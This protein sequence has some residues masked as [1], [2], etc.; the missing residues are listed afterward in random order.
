M[1]AGFTMDRSA[2][3]APLAISFINTTQGASVKA[4]YEWNFGNG[5]TSLLKDPG[6]VFLDARSYAI[7]LTVKDSNKTSSVTQNIIVY[8]KPAVDFTASLQK[9]CFPLPVTFTA[10]ATAGDGTISQ[11]LW[12]FGDG[13]T[14]Q[15]NSSA[16]THTY[17]AKQNPVI[18]LSVTNS[19]G[20]QATIVKENVVKVL[21]ELKASFTTDKKVLCTLNDAAN[22]INTSTGPGTLSY[23]W[24]FG[25]GQTSTTREPSH[26]YS[27]KG[28][29]AVRL[30]VSSSE[31]CKDTLLQNESL[32]VANYKTDWETT[33][34]LCEENLVK[35]INKSSPAPDQSQWDFGN[36]YP[37]NTTN[38]NVET[39]YPVSGT[40]NVK[41][42]NTFGNCTDVLNKQVIVHDIPQLS[43]F[44]SEISGVCGAP[45]NVN[46]KD[47]TTGAVKWEW[48]ADYHN[49]QSTLKEPSTEFTYD[50]DW[51]VY[52]KVFNDKGCSNITSKYL[53]IRRPFV[54]INSPD[55]SGNGS[56]NS[57][58]PKTA[59]FFTTSSVDIAAYQWNFGD[60]G[61]STDAKPVHT[62]SKEGDY[63]VNLSYTTVT[64]CTGT[65]EFDGY[66]AIRDKVKAD[67]TVS[68]TN[69][70]GNTPLYI[71]SN[72]TAPYYWHN[73]DMGDGVLQP[74]EGHQ[75]E[76]WYKY[77]K[78]GIYTVRLAISNGIC[79]DTLIKTNLIKVSPPFPKI[80]GF[81]NTC[82]GTRGTVTFTQTSKQANSWHWDFGDGTTLSLNTDQPEVKHTY[83]KTG[84]YKV[85]LNT[86]NGAC[87]VGDSILVNVLLKQH[88]VLTADKTVICRTEDYL[89]IT[90]SNLERNPAYY[91]HYGYGYGDW[92][93]RDGSF[94]PGHVSAGS[95]NDMPFSHTLWDFTPGP[96]RQ[97]L[98]LVVT[99]NYF[100]CRDTTNWIPLKINGPIPGFKQIISNPC[101]NGSMITLQDTSRSSDNVALKSWEWNF[102]DGTTQTTT[103]RTVTHSYGW[104]GTYPVYLKVTDVNGCYA[105][106][107]G[108]ANAEKNSLD[109]NFIASATT[110]SPGTTINFSNTSVT[111][112]IDHTTYKWLLGDGSQLTTYDAVKTYTQPGLYTVKLIARNTLNGCSDTASLVITVK[113]INAAFNIDQSHTSISQCPP[114]LVK[115]TNISSNI[116]KITWDFG[117]GTIVND[118]FNP[119]HIYT[120]PGKYKIVLLTESDNG[121]K[122][123]TEDSVIIK[124]PAATMTA[125]ILHSCTAQTI[126]LSAITENA[127]NYLWD[128]G[129]GTVI[130]S[131]DTFSAHRYQAAGIYEPKLI[132]ADANGCAAPVTLA[133]KIVIDSLFISLDN[134]PE[135]ICSPK[136]VWLDPTIVSVAASQGQQSLVYHWNFGTGNTRDTSNIQ[137]PSFVYQQPGTYNVT[138]TVKS[139]YGC[140]KETTH[141]IVAYQGLGGSINGPA[142]ICEETTAQF[143]G[144]T[145]IPGQPKWEWIFHD[146]TV[147]KQQN[148]PAKLYETPG[149]Y[150]VKLLVDNNGCV[151]TLTHLL[152]VKAKPAITL[153]AKELLLCQGSLLKITAGGGSVYAWSPAIGLNTTT[154]AE[155]TASPLNDMVYTVTVT[156]ADGCKNTDSVNITVAYPFTLQLDN[157]ATICSGKSIELKASGADSYQWIQNTI[158]LNNT[159]IANPVATPAI[160][161]TYTVRA[162]DANHCFTN[163]ASINVIVQ[164]LPTIDAGPGAELFAGATYQIKPTASNDVINWNWSPAKYLSCSNCPSPETKPLEPMTYAVVVTNAA[165]C[166]ATDTVVIKMLC[167]K[168]KIYVP[169]A[170]T[171]NNDGLNDKFILKGYGINKVKYLRIYN[172]WGELVFERNNFQM[173]D[174]GSA[175]DGTYK[176]LLVPNGAYI[177]MAE[178]SCNDQV[179]TEKGT[180]TV[181]Y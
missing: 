86:T 57:C 156:N 23:S 38:I 59:S 163:T 120:K 133:D 105:Y 112:D 121:T 95:L 124:A 99:S 25:D 169:S 21:E 63:R 48:R 114:V 137:R 47:T 127:A 73:W 40:Y 132:A 177:Y 30:A 55:I 2:G 82:E 111:S 141:S 9:G 37:Q 46:F 41:L 6:A 51:Y 36:A 172:R 173:N 52:L 22:F 157:E 31:G 144:V 109:A 108:Y 71:K 155:V 139:P 35:I 100:G 16:T 168:S 19:Y 72:V 14:E 70:C 128:F 167:D 96:G 58:G 116:S 166:T 79:F 117:D 54:K 83:T 98:R 104:P 8:K 53:V 13:F 151:D 67:F 94:A 180:V 158:G 62:Y 140:L 77:E 24:D 92:H 65:V 171:P 75:K 34:L 175:W 138:L 15:V 76:M 84:W 174:A 45:V 102:G 135:K 78:D 18:N 49:F 129:D 11:Y 131:L 81:S 20:C 149:S 130:Q 142:S 115:F 1:K 4:V 5:N 17:T 28:I 162:I 153:S 103:T 136:E 69:I 176:G 88:P 29:Y 80:A 123:T 147:I 119:S 145:L 61:S 26:T 181:V 68:A 42:T 90:V 165:G 56:I 150:P 164:S 178:M 32:N 60:G 10:N 134:L 148:P 118:V 85:V 122:Y 152:E 97:D 44:I 12:D 110:I 126:T 125:D 50:N 39:W 74:W 143:K 93:H 3:C 91:S 66:V 161:T 87:T 33:G 113:Y 101:A 160:S 179:F 107:Q 154:G 64:G 159:Q 27:A 7:T 43:G 146:G 89:T 170:F 106:Y